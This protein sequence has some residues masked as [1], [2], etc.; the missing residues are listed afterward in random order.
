[1]RYLVAKY[2]QNISSWEAQRLILMPT[3]W[4]KGRRP[5]NR[6]RGSRVLFLFK[7]IFCFLNAPHANNTR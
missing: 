3:D 6:V 7:S 1:L 4:Q 2:S 5:L